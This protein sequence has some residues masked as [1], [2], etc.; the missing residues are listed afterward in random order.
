M[1]KRK[2]KKGSAAILTVIVLLICVSL[3]FG[4]SMLTKKNSNE[5][6]QGSQSQMLEENGNLELIIPEDQ[7]AGGF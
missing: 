4:I 7:E 6:V 2:M 3:Y 1:T 5:Q